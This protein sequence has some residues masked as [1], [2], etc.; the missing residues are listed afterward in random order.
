VIPLSQK[1]L[2]AKFRP[3][4]QRVADARAPDPP[5]A[6][7]VAVFAIH[8]ISP[9]QRYAFQD[10]VALALQS[11]LNASEPANST[12]T[13]KSIVHW[14]TVATDS[15][16]EDVAVRPSALR[17]YQSGD[18]PNEPA[19]RVYDIYE[20]YWSPL[21]K[22]KANIASAAKWLLNATFLGNSNTANV[23][24]SPGKLVFDLLY[25]A[26]L[27]IGALLAFAFAFWCGYEAWQALVA[28]LALKLPA[29]FV[30]LVQNPF[31]T[32]FKFPRLVYVE[33]LIYLAIGY[34]V[35]QI[36]TSL[37]AARKREGRRRTISGDAS[38]RGHFESA[39]TG[40]HTFHLIMFGLLV[41]IL[42]ALVW[43]A[44]FVSRSSDFTADT[45]IYVGGIVG[46][47]AFIQAA[48][49]IAD[50]AVEN[51]LGDVEVYTTHDE[52]SA[53]YVVRGAIIAAVTIA[54]KGVLNAVSTPQAPAGKTDPE[55]EPYYDAVHVLGHSLG[56]T[57]AM[58]VLILLRQLIE[59]NSLADRQ[60]KRIRSFTTFGSALEKTRFFFDVR[61]PNLNAAQDQWQD[62]VYGRFFTSALTAL[63][64]PTNA[65]GIYWSNL[66]YFRDV[67]SNAIVSYQSDCNVGSFQFVSARR[68]IC[69]D[70]QLPHK[71]FLFAWVHSDYLGD[72]L[73][74]Q[75]A[76]PVLT[77]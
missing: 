34:V 55:Q 62:D 59:E 39:T 58:D 28:G 52:N 32:L 68:A 6:K 10:Q 60:W 9:I 20:G 14:P 43:L 3:I 71:R 44:W 5:D 69:Q 21:S 38:S 30:D 75:R 13:W 57:I 8:G 11:Y 4:A 67:V 25:V 27:I 17:L 29:T 35:A 66:W 48:R 63:D 76:G 64:T 65:D 54:L 41:V 31:Q 22:G 45:W 70:Y 37:N 73:F 77:R 12:I 1:D 47:V 7:R 36:V 56:S 26:A 19:R 49:S 53:Y 33:I 51:V 72:P 61:Q 18:D 40:A 42:A 16:G 74:W 2:V 50:F 23:P 15:S 24:C 46:F